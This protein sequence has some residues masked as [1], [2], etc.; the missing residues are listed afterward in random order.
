[1]IEVISLAQVELA[2]QAV[3]NF[4]RLGPT[5]IKLGQILSIRCQLPAA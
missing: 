4:Q 3:N 5:F 1:M 2:R